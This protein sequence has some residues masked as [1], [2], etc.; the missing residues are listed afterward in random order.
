MCPDLKVIKVT[1]DEFGET[2]L[3]NEV[4]LSCPE[5]AELIYTP[6]LVRLY[7]GKSRF[8][9]INVVPLEDL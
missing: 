5:S 2:L 1:D 9:E 7:H 8:F 4:V 6:D 3:S